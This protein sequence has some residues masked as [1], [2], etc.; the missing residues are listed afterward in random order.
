MKKIFG[1][2]TVKDVLLD[3]A[4]TAFGTAGTGGFGVKNSSLAEYSPYLQSVTTVFMLLFGV[5]LVSAGSLLSLNVY[6]KERAKK[7]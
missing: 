1:D 3:L 7:Q 6:L 5:L 4:C 2:Y